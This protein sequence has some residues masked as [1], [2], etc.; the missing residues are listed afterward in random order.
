MRIRE[1]IT[2]M[3][4]TPVNKIAVLLTEHHSGGLAV[5]DNKN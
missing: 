2:I 1:L 4:D 3:T 5:V